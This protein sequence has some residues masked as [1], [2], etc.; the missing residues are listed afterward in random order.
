MSLQEKLEKLKE[1]TLIKIES[2]KDLVDLHER[3]ESNSSG[4]A[5]KKRTHH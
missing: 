4:S 1:E 3:L 2:V 5:W